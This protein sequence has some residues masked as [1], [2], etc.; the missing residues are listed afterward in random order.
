MC[1]SGSATWTRRRWKTDCRLGYAIDVRFEQWRQRR[2]R[3]PVRVE[4]SVLLGS[5]VAISS[6]LFFRKSN[7]G[8]WAHYERGDGSVGQWVAIV[9]GKLCCSLLVQFCN[10]LNSNKKKKKKLALLANHN[11]AL[12]ENLP[13]DFPLRRSVLFVL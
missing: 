8:A 4:V 3:V 12:G 2:A 9:L 13:G 10:W 11:F 7:V 5:M 1:V 6:W